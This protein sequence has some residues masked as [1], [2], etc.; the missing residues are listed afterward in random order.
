MTRTLQVTK[1]C[2]DGES[3]FHNQLLSKVPKFTASLIYPLLFLTLILHSN[4]RRLKKKKK[5]T[6]ESRLQTKKHKS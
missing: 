2:Q 1:A 4:T 3:S 5:E 6:V